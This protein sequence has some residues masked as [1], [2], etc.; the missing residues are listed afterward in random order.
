MDCGHKTFLI[1]FRSFVNKNPFE[2]KQYDGFRKMQST[3]KKKKT[4]IRCNRV[5]FIII[6][7][8]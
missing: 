4:I 6:I 8:L 7:Q 5:K 1:I 2:V 3:S